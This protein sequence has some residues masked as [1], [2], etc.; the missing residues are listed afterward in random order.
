MDESAVAKYASVRRCERIY[1]VSGVAIRRAIRNGQ[2][3]GVH[4]G[5]KLL[6]DLSSVDAHFTPARRAANTTR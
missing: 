1:D 3:R 6:I 5:R 4:F 2:I